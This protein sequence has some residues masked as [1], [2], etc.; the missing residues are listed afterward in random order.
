MNQFKDKNVQ[1]DAIQQQIKTEVQNKLNGLGLQDKVVDVEVKVNSNPNK[2]Q[3]VV[4]VI[5]KFKP[6]LNI[7]NSINDTNTNTK[8]ENQQIIVSKDMS[9]NSG[10]TDKPNDNDHQGETGQGGQ[11]G[12]G[13]G[14]AGEHQN[15]GS[16]EVPVKTPLSQ[17]QINK[18]NDV[19]D[20]II[21]NPSH[22]ITKQDLDNNAHKQ[23]IENAIKQTLEK[24]NIP[25]IKDVTITVGNTTNDKTSINVNVSFDNKTE[26]NG[27][28]NSNITVDKDT[29]TITK[30]LDVNN[31][32]TVAPAP[33]DPDANKPGTEGGEVG[34]GTEG[35]EQGDQP[36]HDGHQ[37]VPSNSKVTISQAQVDKVGQAID[38][39]INNDKHPI[40]NQDLENQN[41]KKQIIDAIKKA[42]A[43]A[44]VDNVKDVTIT[45]DS[46]T[47]GKVNINVNVSFNDNTEFGNEVADKDNIKINKDTHTVTETLEINDKPVV[48]PGPE[49]EEPGTSGSGQGGESGDAGQG[50]QGGSE[51]HQNDD[52]HQTPSKATI[53]QE[54]LNKI[55]DELNKLFNENGHRPITKQDLDNESDKNKI[56]DAIKKIFES[57]GFP[58]SSITNVQ[59]TYPN[60][61][62]ETKS[63]VNVVIS[64][65][66]DQ[67]EL[68][69]DTTTNVEGLNINKTAHS[70][71][72]T[73]EIDNVP[74][75]E[76][77]SRLTPIQV[78]Q[79]AMVQAILVVVLLKVVVLLGLLQFHQLLLDNL[80]NLL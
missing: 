1:E 18:V 53:S 38:K 11:G 52:S 54:Q 78:I 64:F 32:P 73:L 6:D 71:T 5:I 25:N 16:H 31:Q 3:D 37:D 74:A 14:D 67:I 79:V 23:A 10:G 69:A 34:Q 21:N 26:I 12:T 80:T 22:P 49:P 30:T 46:V 44:G 2:N 58:V 20:Q 68:G 56:V 15:D 17:E 13:T 45:T 27:N 72:K 66:G 35:G 61:S 65:N 40:T 7:D 4:K 9:I 48:V 29:N 77:G 51:G 55:N 36:S 76:G 60:N 59:F 24:N 39:I 70:I 57:N 50:G 47:D 19:I 75:T 62:T 43:D 41:H 28:S 8:V 63:T 42:L 33:V